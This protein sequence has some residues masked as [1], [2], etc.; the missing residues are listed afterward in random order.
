MLES[1]LALGF[2]LGNSVLMQKILLFN[3]SSASV[4]FSNALLTLLFLESDLLLARLL[5]LGKLALALELISLS[6][7]SL[8]FLLGRTL[9]L[10]SLGGKHAP[11][12]GLLLESQALGLLLLLPSLL[13]S[14]ELLLAKSKLF[15]V[16]LGL[17]T[18]GLLQLALV[19]LGELRRNHGLVLLFFL[20]ESRLLFFKG[21]ATSGIFSFVFESVGLVHGSQL[22][23]TVF[24]V[25]LSLQT[26]FFLFFG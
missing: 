22:F 10:R 3:P 16:P 13:L 12:C 20:L 7:E 25:G 1:S 6:L 19:H 2:F 11:F 4:V 14:L 24:F 9:L 8:F 26:G 21:L 5:F 23:L 17:Q 15:F 18:L